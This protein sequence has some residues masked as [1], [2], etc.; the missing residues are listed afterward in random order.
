VDRR[1]GGPQAR[2][3]GCKTLGPTSLQTRIIITIVRFQVVT[4][5]SMKTAV[6]WD[7][8]SCSLIDDRFFRG[9]A[10]TDL[11]MEAA[12]TSEKIF[13]FYETTRRNM[14]EDKSSSSP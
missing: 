9:S 6:F 7:V 4:A 8:V 3:G 10:S 11:M 14:P 1:L 5:A 12:S 13:K 2:C